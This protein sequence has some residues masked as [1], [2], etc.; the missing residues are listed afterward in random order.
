MS[1]QEDKLL[2]AIINEL[3][4]VE[5]KLNG[6]FV[7]EKGVI[8]FKRWSDNASIPMSEVLSGLSS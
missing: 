5:E 1:E 7:L 3:N 8:V 2:H 4:G 6:S